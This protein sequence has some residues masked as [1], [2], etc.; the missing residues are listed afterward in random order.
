MKC[1]ANKNAFCSWV[2]ADYA[3]CPHTGEK[4]APTDFSI[5]NFPNYRLGASATPCYGVAVESEIL[6]YLQV[7]PNPAT[8][9]LHISFDERATLHIV[10]ALGQEVY[11]ESSFSGEKALSLESFAT[12]VYYVKAVTAKGQ[13]FVAKFFKE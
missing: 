3:Q 1:H 12:G 7:Y 9:T 8:T 5:P 6:R 10:N 2:G 13:V 11:R 4:S